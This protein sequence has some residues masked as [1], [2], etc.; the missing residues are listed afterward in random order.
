MTRSLPV[1]QV[2]RRSTLLVVA[3]A[4]SPDGHTIMSLGH[5]ENAVLLP[6]AE[7]LVQWL[8]AD[9]RS[10][11]LLSAADS[12]LP[13]LAIAIQ[14]HERCLGALLL[15]P[16]GDL[17]HARLLPFPSLTVCHPPQAHRPRLTSTVAFA[18][19]WGSRL[20]TLHGSGE[21]ALGELRLLLHALQRQAE[22]WPL[23]DI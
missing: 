5:Q 1:E 4:R 23:G 8:A 7:A 22:G 14:Q 16:G 6:N 15:S 3:D 10:F 13:S 20:H 21:S 12:C 18:S 11:V 2:S 19:S 9:Q 17:A